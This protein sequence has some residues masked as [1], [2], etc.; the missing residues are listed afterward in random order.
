MDGAG[1]TEVHWIGTP[2][3]GVRENELERRTPMSETN[4]GKLAGMGNF[5]PG[6]GVWIR[7][8]NF[9]TRSFQKSLAKLAFCALTVFGA[10]LGKVWDCGVFDPG[11]SCF[12][13]NAESV[14]NGAKPFALLLETLEQ[15]PDPSVPLRSLTSV[16]ECSEF[17][18][19]VLLYLE[20]L[21][22]RCPE[23]KRVDLF[24][25]L[26][27]HLGEAGETDHAVR[28]CENAVKL[29][30]SLDAAAE[31]EENEAGASDAEEDPLI[32]DEPQPLIWEVQNQLSFQAIYFLEKRPELGTRLAELRENTPNECTPEVLED[33]FSR[34]MYFVSENQI[35]CLRAIQGDEAGARAQFAK[36]KEKILLV[37]DFEDRLPLAEMLFR[38][39]VLLKDW[40]LGEKMFREVL[41][42]REAHVTSWG[43]R[44]PDRADF[45]LRLG[46]YEKAREVENSA[47][48][49]G[50]ILSDRMQKAIW[51][52][53]REMADSI[54]AECAP[55][56]EM[57]DVRDDLLEEMARWMMGKD[58]KEAQKY[59]FQM[60]PDD[61][62]TY[63]CRHI[64]ENWMMRGELENAL[65]VVR[66]FHHPKTRLAILRGCAEVRKLS[67]ENRT[68]LAEEL[69]KIP[70]DVWLRA[71][72]EELRGF[73]KSS[74]KR[75]EQKA[76]S[77]LK[78]LKA[79]VWLRLGKLEDA[80][81]AILEIQEVNADEMTL[82]YGQG[83]RKLSAELETELKFRSFRTPE[84]AI[85]FFNGLEEGALY[86]LEPAAI[87]GDQLFLLTGRFA[88][89][90][91]LALI[92]DPA[93]RADL[94]LR[95]HFLHCGTFD[96]LLREIEMQK[97]LI[98]RQ[99][100]W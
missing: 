58:L 91:Y 17:S 33:S 21:A 81:R 64:A 48:I 38:Q 75:I 1:Q 51:V 45:Y 100:S 72:Q 32:W 69:R 86:T 56:P 10:I 42:S 96:E 97:L 78:L 27:F 11:S 85:R 53:D 25:D 90:E 52:E 4:A 47:F 80:E 66:K 43:F 82:S 99:Y 12:A 40:E 77:R 3:D 84:E 24:M 13:Q 88:P 92:E 79:T 41:E 61:A 63:L 65:A 57:H 94:L 70:E 46:E 5:A 68:R 44:N 16:R 14:S 67:L 37:P 23:P 6:P 8:R 29:A 9:G 93:D 28:L 62:R 60:S 35:F 76:K 89:E 19:E 59:A 87:L 18:P 71:I 49:E 54:L 20:K 39:V 55:D 98:G 50:R 2:M 15:M 34:L 74:E 73:T 36:I 26:A 95:E 31:A 30:N 22:L 83:W 7:G